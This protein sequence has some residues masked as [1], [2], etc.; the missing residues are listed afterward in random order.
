MTTPAK[1]SKEKT[2]VTAKVVT[3]QPPK[4]LL[5]EGPLEAAQDYVEN[6]FPRHHVDP[7]STV[8]NPQTDVH[9]ETSDG[10]TMRYF[11]E[12]WEPVK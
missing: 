3:V 2:P 10:Q 8:E 11:G 12:E 6:N 9:V 4:R 5:F 1:E 7:T